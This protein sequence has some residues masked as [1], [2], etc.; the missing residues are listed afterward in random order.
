MGHSNVFSGCGYVVYRRLFALPLLLLVGCSTERPS[1]SEAAPQKPYVLPAEFSLKPVAERGTEG[2]IYISGTTNF[3]D[4]MKMWV[5]V[6][7]KKAQQDAFVRDGKFRSAPL[8]QDVPVPLS[9]SQPVE[10]IA[11]FNGAW[12]NQS[13]LSVIGEGGKNLHGSLFK[14]TDTDVV[15]SDRILDAKFTLPLPPVAPETNAISIVKHAIL[16]VPGKG[17]S[18]TDIAENIKLFES[19]G[20]GVSPGKG[21]SATPAGAGIYDVSY[22]FIDGSAGAKQAIWSVNPAKK[23]VRYVNEAAKAFSWTPN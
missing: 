1:V 21:W 14:Q 22:D 17:R 6:G 15:D 8:F 5:V 19:P 13:V 2:E 16:T 20:T 18:A 9:G 12:Q 7:R 3:P 4:G 10:I 23:Q 11:Y